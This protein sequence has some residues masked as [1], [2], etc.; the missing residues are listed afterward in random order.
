MTRIEREAVVDPGTNRIDQ[1]L[2]IADPKRWF[3]FG[4]GA[5]DRYLFLAT[6]RDASG[7]SHT[8]QRNTGLRTVELRREKDK[9]GKS[10]ELVV[11]DIP[12]FAKGANLIRADF[13]GALVVRCDFSAALL[14][15]ARIDG[16]RFVDCNFVGADLPDGLRRI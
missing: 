9:W 16:A 2:R 4:Y 7:D 8:V 5:Q 10:M 12:I 14:S 11:N 1:P 13:S 6:L 15:G 3:P